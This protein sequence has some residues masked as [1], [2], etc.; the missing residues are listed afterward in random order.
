MVSA[1]IEFQYVLQKFV[2][3]CLSSGLGMGLMN[4]QQTVRWDIFRGITWRL[5]DWSNACFMRLCFVMP[6]DS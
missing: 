5:D 4:P 2:G 6:T 1:A 3:A